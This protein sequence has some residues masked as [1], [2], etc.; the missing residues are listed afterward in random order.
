MKP[1]QLPRIQ[2]QDPVARLVDFLKTPSEMPLLAATSDLISVVH[3]A[4]KICD[5]IARS[6]SYCIVTSG[7][8]VCPAGI[9]GCNVI[10]HALAESL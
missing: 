4:S 5:Q 9:S 8:P 6:A 2:V 10:R 1:S 3:F 7:F